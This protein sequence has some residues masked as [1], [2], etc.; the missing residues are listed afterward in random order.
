[1]RQLNSYPQKG[2]DITHNKDLGAQ[3]EVLLTEIQQF[4]VFV[5][6][7][8]QEIKAFLMKRDLK[9]SKPRFWG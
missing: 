5:E 9:K 7:W 6:R 2:S 4:P 3:D 8:P 1:M